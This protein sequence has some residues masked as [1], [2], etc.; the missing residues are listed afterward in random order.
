M[1]TEKERAMYDT[2][3]KNIRVTCK[4]GV[5]VEGVCE[6]F[7]QPLDNEPE[8]AEICI[9]RGTRGLTGITEPEIEK[10]EYLN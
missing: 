3:G 8:I 2:Q 1:L 5:V 7:T 4:N 9:R 6:F 10:I